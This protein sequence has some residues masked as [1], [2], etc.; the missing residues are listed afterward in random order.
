MVHIDQP[1]ALDVLARIEGTH[2]RFVQEKNTSDACGFFFWRRTWAAKIAAGLRDVPVPLASIA[3]RATR[4][5]MIC[6]AEGHHRYHVDPWGEIVLE[7]ESVLPDEKE[8]A[9]ALGFRLT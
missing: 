9:E 2:W 5:A 6:G 8:R 1:D 4:G 3:E 7:R